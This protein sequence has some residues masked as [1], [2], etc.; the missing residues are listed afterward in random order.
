MPYMQILFSPTKQMDSS[1]QASRGLAELSR[2]LKTGTP[3]FLGE[4]RT[5]NGLLKEMNQGELASLMKISE[6]L[7]RQTAE[8]V[9]SFEKQ[10]GKPALFSYTGTG[11]KALD[12]GSLDSE[13]LSF[14]SRRLW[15]PSGMYGL[16]RPFDLISPYRLE[17]KTPLPAGG[18][19][20]LSSYWSSLVTDS[21]ASEMD[22]LSEDTL[23]NL[24]SGEYAG[25]LR[26]KGKGKRMIT[27]HF[28]DKSASGYRSIAMY[29]KRA[30]GLMLRRILTEK[31]DNPDDIKEIY[32]D[33]YEYRSSLSDPL[34]WVFTRDR[35]SA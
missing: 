20:R 27:I 34:N 16:L 32:V 13:S 5:I 12:A 14:A 21:L 4:A 28:K 31:M 1:S 22:A 24:A 25:I 23:L 33:D 11:F 15:I 9:S 2:T 35:S 30:R 8:T 29:A 18:A 6:T 3:R 26:L 19:S 7:A 17:M 10:P